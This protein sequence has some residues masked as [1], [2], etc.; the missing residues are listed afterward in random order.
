MY[1]SL[2]QRLKKKKKIRIERNEEKQKKQEEWL[3][4]LKNKNKKLNKHERI[5]QQNLRKKKK[6]KLKNESRK[7]KRKKKKGKNP[8]KKE[9]QKKKQNEQ[10]NGNGNKHT[11]ANKKWVK[12]RRMRK[13]CLRSEKR[14]RN[15]VDEMHKKLIKWLDVNH[16]IVLLPKFETQQMVT[17]KK[18]DGK[19]RNINKVT[20]RSMCSWAHYR[21]R[22]RLIDRMGDRVIVCSERYTSKGC[23]YCGKNNHNL[24]SSKTF[25]CCCQNESYDRDVH[26]SRNIFLMNA[27]LLDLS[28]TAQPLV[29]REW[30]LDPPVH[31][32]VEPH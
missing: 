8:T 22:K 30:C 3:K 4:K 9:R 15:L 29:E 27:T 28:H 2:P 26:A 19:K 5:K 14:I 10:N 21:F 1:R 32:G 6:K 18:T 13:A 23:G 24:G 11:L 12:Y 17:K 31:S 20:A 16:D 7:R 25:K